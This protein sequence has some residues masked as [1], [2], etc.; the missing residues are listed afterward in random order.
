MLNKEINQLTKLLRPHF[1]GNLSRIEC[2]AA[3]ILGIYT[4]QG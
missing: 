2:M 1:T 4:H 3:I